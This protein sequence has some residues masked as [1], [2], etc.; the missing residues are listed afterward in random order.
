MKLSEEHNKEDTKKPSLH[1]KANSKE[2]H[3][4]GGNQGK[5]MNFFFMFI[6]SDVMNM[7]T[8]LWIVDIMQGKMLEV[9]ITSKMLEM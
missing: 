6:S 3:L 4:Q 8:N 7:V 9:S 1:L 5:D 2:R